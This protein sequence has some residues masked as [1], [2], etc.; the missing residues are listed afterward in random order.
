[1]KSESVS[2]RKARGKQL[3]RLVL[4]MAQTHFAGKEDRFY[5]AVLQAAAAL[6]A[7]GQERMARDLRDIVE[8]SR[9][10]DTLF[11]NAASP[12][13]PLAQPRGELAGLMSVSYPTAH[14]SS[15]IMAQQLRERLERVV[16][17][18]H[19]AAELAGYG[20]TAR[21]KLLL[22]GP[23]GTGKTYTA[24]ALAGELRLP[25][26]TVH[27]DALVTR[28]LGET[29]QKLRLVFDGLAATRAVYLFDEF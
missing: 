22:S 5:V 15:L 6:E 7:E 9:P 27:V 23:P 3:H 25:L 28:F 19:G 12:A 1:M 13:I 4:S 17:E 20:L 10:R 16:A 26:M 8:K 11:A 29:S 2:Q 21:R 14:I 24:S 18:Q